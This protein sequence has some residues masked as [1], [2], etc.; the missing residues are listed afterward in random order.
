MK[1]ILD[2]IVSLMAWTSMVC[3]L[4]G[5]YPPLVIMWIILGPFG[6]QFKIMHYYS[7]FWAWTVVVSNIYW[8]VRVIDRHKLVRGKPCVFI[9]NHQSMADIL[10]LFLLFV[11]FRFVSKIELF[12]L[13]LIGWG[14][15][16]VGHIK[17]N[18]LNRKTFIRTYSRC[19]E[20]LKE[21]IPVMIFP[22]GTRTMDGQLNHFKEGAFRIA[23]HDKVSIQPI[24]INGS[25]DA[26][27]HKNL[28]LNGRQH[29]TM[30]VLDEVPYEKFPSYES[31]EL[32]TYFRNIYM[33]EISR[34]S[35]TKQS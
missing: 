22:E 29:I 12:R 14:M 2:I 20:S 33:E 35:S 25:W 26:L 31:M 3:L 9:C 28:I 1:K 27:P 6:K 10:V 34:L 17:L 4:I 8:S 5:L 24:I 15:A 19:E 32:S 13:P 7:S 23:L 11:P 21:G 16:M 18:R 30:K